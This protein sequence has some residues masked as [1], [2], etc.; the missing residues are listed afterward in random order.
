MR[1]QRLVVPARR[2]GTNGIAVVEAL[3]LVRSATA[4]VLAHRRTGHTD[5]ELLQHD[6]VV[7]DRNGDGGSVDV[8]TFQQGQRQRILDRTLQHP[9]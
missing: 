5:R 2:T 1:A 8:T 9:P 4:N 7:V 3:P 6:V